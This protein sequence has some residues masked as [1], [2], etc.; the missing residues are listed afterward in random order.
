M[1]Q[2]RI[3][4]RTR[5]DAFT[6]SKTSCSRL[7][8]Y[9]GSSLALHVADG[10]GRRGPLAD[11][12]DDLLVQS[13]DLLPPVCYLHHKLLVSEFCSRRYCPARNPRNKLTNRLRRIR[14]SD[15][16]DQRHQRTANNRRIRKLADRPH[17]R[18]IRNAEPDRNRQLGKLPQTALPAPARRL[19]LCPACP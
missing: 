5:V 8:S 9:T 11:E 15:L 3:R 12:R 10:L 6:C 19:P 14:R 2:L 1:D 13:V 17:M 16:L 18:R 7:G 4:Q